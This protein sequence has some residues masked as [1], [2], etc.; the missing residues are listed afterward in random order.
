MSLELRK[1]GTPLTRDAIAEYARAHGI[2]IPEPLV[3]LLLE[4]N[5]GKLD[6]DYRAPT[7]DGTKTAGLHL[8]GLHGEA[9]KLGQRDL[10]ARMAIADNRPASWLTPFAED[11]FG[12]LF[13]LSTRAADVD[14]VWF[15]D[16]ESAQSRLACESL[17]AFLEA[18]EYVP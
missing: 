6:D 8:L 1:S 9:K 16:H 10:A 12:N 11:A 15:W 4:H 3:A 13:A 14:S 7:G 17:A 18:L 2:Q 5:G